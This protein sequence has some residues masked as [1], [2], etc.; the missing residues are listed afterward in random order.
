MLPSMKPDFILLSIS[1]AIRRPSV[2]KHRRETL[3]SCCDA[4][5]R[6]KGKVD[7]SIFFVFVFPTLAINRNL[8]NKT[9]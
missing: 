1:G 4:Q 6:K 7:C 2:S 8:I 3:L 9:S 5:R